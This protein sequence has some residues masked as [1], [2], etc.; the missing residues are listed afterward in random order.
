MKILSIKIHF[1]HPEAIKRFVELVSDMD[2]DFIVSDGHHWVNGQS[3]LGMF[4]LD[5]SKQIICKI[6]IP[7]DSDLD[8]NSILYE[9][10]DYR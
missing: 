2:A 3:I 10:K 4:S 7:A 5:F 6:T 9:L 1:S 8:M